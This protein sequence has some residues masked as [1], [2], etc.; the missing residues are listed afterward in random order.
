M[1]IIVNLIATGNFKSIV[2]TYGPK[3]LDVVLAEVLPGIDESQ[4]KIIMKILSMILTTAGVM[5][6][7]TL[8]EV[9]TD[10]VLED[11]GIPGVTLHYVSVDAVSQEAV[12]A[13]A[14]VKAIIDK[15][16]NVIAA[17]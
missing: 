16:G 12:E 11:L 15:V 14:K 4:S 2:E 6:G 3:L 10:I 13:G 8:E 17:L 5:D 7:P 9:L 1:G